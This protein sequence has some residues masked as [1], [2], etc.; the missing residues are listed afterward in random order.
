M[1]YVRKRDGK[2]ESFD[3]ERICKAIWKASEAVGNPSKDFAYQ[4]GDQVVKELE[5]RFGNDGVPTVE[6]I[7]DTVERVL[8][9]RNLRRMAKAYILYREQHKEL[10]DLASSLNGIDLIDS[11]LRKLDWKV[12]ENSNMTYSLQGLNNYISTEITKTYWLNRIYPES[13]RQAHLSGDFHIH[14]LNLISVYCVGFDLYDV[15]LTGFKGAVDKISSSPAKHFRSA[16]GQIVNF[17]YTLQGEAAGAIAFSNIDTLLSPFIKYDKLT[18]KQV[19]QSLQEFMYNMNVP[20]RVGF[21]TPFTNITLDLVVPPYFKNSPSLIGGKANGEVYG[22]LQN[23]VTLFNKALFSL[24]YK[25]DS[26]GRPFT[27]P[28]PTYNI[29]KS[30]R[31]DNEDLEGLWAVTAKY[32]VPYFANFVSSDMKLEDS[33]SMCCRLRLDLSKLE[34]KGGGYF[35]ANSLTGSIGVVT[36]NLPRLG[37]TSKNEDEFVEKLLELAS[38]AKDSLEIKRK[39]LER[40]TKYNLYPYT[41]FYLRSVKERFGK[42][43]QNHFSTIGLVGMNE[44]LLN[45]MN[46]DIGTK[47]G[48][49]FTIK[50]LKILREELVK[51]QEK[52]GNYY[53]LEAT[54]AEST[55]Y[56]L[57]ILDREKF[58][59]CYFANGKGHEAKDPFYTNSTQLPVNYTDDIFEALELQNEIQSLYTGGT[60][61]HLFL[62]EQIRDHNMVKKLIKRVC[63]NYKIPYLT[64]TPTF[65]VCSNHGYIN[66][67]VSKCPKCG[68]QTEIY[69]RVVGYLRPVSQW[70]RGKQAEFKLRKTF[71][72]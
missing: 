45:L 12:N 21:Q 35:G 16:L 58:G 15:L 3:K 64:I 6:E 66:G 7:Q 2:L 19:E 10:R 61:M 69:S 36:L 55:C 17:M 37:Y 72:V 28:I 33:R 1:R 42:Y 54:P 49:K 47:E 65:S 43:W 11:Y 63:N 4:L 18:Y 9:R 20:T 67:E 26:S 62:G 51:Y 68:K 46:V 44:A 59:D 52:T 24:Y 14:N 27:F 22:E 5:S 38:L 41:K 60:V 39:A 56:R 34:K 71:R 29:S 13:I 30:F 25:G 31:W 50:I 32:G 70:N 57:A 23:E 48:V 53:N 8:I 40:F